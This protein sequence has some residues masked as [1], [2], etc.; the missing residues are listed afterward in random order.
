M[1]EHERCQ[2]RGTCVQLPSCFC[3]DY[4]VLKALHRDNAQAD[5]YQ[6]Q[7][8]SDIP[9]V[10][11]DANISQARNEGEVEG[12]DEAPHQEV[13][14]DTNCDEAADHSFE[15]DYPVASSRHCAG[16]GLSEGI[17][18]LDQSARMMP[19]VHFRNGKLQVGHVH[20]D[21]L[22]WLLCRAH[23]FANQCQGRIE[24]FMIIKKKPRGDESYRPSQRCV[25]CDYAIICRWQPPSERLSH[26]S[27]SLFPHRY[28]L[29]STVVYEKE[30]ISQ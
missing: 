24:R 6:Y 19:I 15:E 7:R 28:I 13:H 22:F 23:F 9:V 30:K 11:R 12:S 21:V 20:H 18:F 16:C 27:V 5:I 8:F 25:R 4:L 2:L 14:G 10:N 17:L 1:V 29:V 3:S 26:A